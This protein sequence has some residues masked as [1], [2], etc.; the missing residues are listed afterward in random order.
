ML[1][2][3]TT[4]LLGVMG[5][6]IAHS[7]SPAMHNAALG[8][9]QLDY[10]YV[11]LLIHPD[12]LGVALSGLTALNWVGC[13]VTI[14]HK[15]TIMAHLEAVTPVAQA[16]GAVNTIWQTATGWQ[17]TNTDIVGFMAPLQQ[18]AQDWAGLSAVVLGSGGAARAVVAACQAL[19]CASITVVG[20][21]RA[22]LAAFR[23]SWSEPVAVATWDGLDPLLSKTGLVVNCT[24][25][26]MAPQVAA[27]PIT[28]AQLARLPEG[29]I[30]YDLIYTP[31]P[32]ELLRLA[33]AAGYLAIDG[34]EMLVFQGVAAWN[35][36]LDQAAP[37]AVMRQALL[38]H[39]AGLS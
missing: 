10:V 6:P 14:P 16:I 28:A 25:I 30:V 23:A 4:K 37:V 1:I 31:R 3:G 29:A 19:G 35:H 5:Y 22:K 20:R 9:G 34:S 17:G 15:Q 18:L 2:T 32:T 12:R 21:D 33:A 13:S 36:W 24:P 27:S 8:H 38:D 11:P 7:L 39:L 26:G